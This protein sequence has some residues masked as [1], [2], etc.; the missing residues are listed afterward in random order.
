MVYTNDWVAF[1]MYNCSFEN[2]VQN[3]NSQSNY[4]TVRYQQ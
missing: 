4:Q 3:Y 2:K 1:D